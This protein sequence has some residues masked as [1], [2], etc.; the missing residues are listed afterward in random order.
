M[1]PLFI[2]VQLSFIFFGSI[3][4]IVY[5]YQGK[6]VRH[7]KDRLM[8]CEIE[9][10]ELPQR[11]IRVPSTYGSYH[12]QPPPPPPPPPSTSQHHHPPRPT[13]SIKMNIGSPLL[14][15][16]SDYALGYAFK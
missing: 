13:K 5:Q 10:M 7:K 15:A 6:T 8:T 9:P 4:S 11:Q 14:Q 12:R 1:L 16:T 2:C 3:M